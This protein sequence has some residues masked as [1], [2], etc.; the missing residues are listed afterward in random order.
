MAE[1]VILEDVDQIIFLLSEH[2]KNVANLYHNYYKK[3]PDHAVWLHLAQSKQKNH[4]FLQRFCFAPK[5]LSPRTDDSIFKS[6]A[7]KTSME[8]VNRL[9]EESQKHD[10]HTAL[11]YSLDLEQSKI[12]QRYFDVFQNDAPEIKDILPNITK[13]AQ[14]YI[15]IIESE[16]R[17]LGQN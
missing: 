10:I 8:W 12:D 3:F 13:E 16:L 6:S 15:A 2:K 5:K 11:G 14:E 7:I 17:K 4:E 9:I 1:V